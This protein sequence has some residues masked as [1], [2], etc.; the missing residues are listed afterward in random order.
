MLVLGLTAT[1]LPL[2][3]LLHVVLR[4]VGLVHLPIGLRVSRRNVL[5]RRD[6]GGRGGADALGLFDVSRLRFPDRHGEGVHALRPNGG[7]DVA[8]V[9]RQRRDVVLGHAL[10]AQLP[11]QLPC[12]AAR[13]LEDGETADVGEDGVAHGAGQVVQ[14][15]EALSRQHED[16]PNFPS[17]LS[18]DS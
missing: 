17:S 13:H 2:F 3:L 6:V 16:A 11:H 14:L 4:L 8:L 12:V 10:L 15:G 9:H 18:I 7:P 1:L 5:G